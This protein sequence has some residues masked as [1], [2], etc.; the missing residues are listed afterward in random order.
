[1][2]V[3]AARGARSTGAPLIGTS[4]PSTRTRAGEPGSQ[5]QVGP[6]QA[7]DLLQI[8]LDRIDLDAD[9]LSSAF[10]SSA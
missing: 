8:D 7:D 2:I 5:Q 4:R 1:M 3:R 6:A 10:T 9:R